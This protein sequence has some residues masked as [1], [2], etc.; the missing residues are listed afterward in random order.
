MAKKVILFI[1]EGINDQTCLGGVLEQILDSNEVRFQMTCGDITTRNVIDEYNIKREIGTVVKQF[2]DKYHLRPEHFMEVVHLIDM[3]GAFISEDCIFEEDTD[4]V[5][6]K[7]TGIY[8][9]KVLKLKERNKKKSAVIERMLDITKVLKIIP[10]SVYYFSSNMDH[11]FHDDANLSDD[12]KN[13]LADEFDLKYTE[14]I[15]GFK[16]LITESEF[17]VKGTYE[18]TW[19]FIKLDNNSVCRYSN[20][21]TYFD[22]FT[23]KNY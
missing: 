8:T 20:F 5:I 4:K 1:V 7:D 15:E 2:K 9:N 3:D 17:S 16:K 22:K 18:E 11:V 13:I 14:D 21:G 6:Y 10:Y 19:S 23:S 12:D